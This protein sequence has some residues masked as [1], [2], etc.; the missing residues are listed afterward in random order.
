MDCIK[1]HGSGLH[2]RRYFINHLGGDVMKALAMFGNILVAI[3]IVILSICA[4]ILGLIGGASS[5]LYE[6]Y[7]KITITAI[8]CFIGLW[9]T[10]SIAAIVGSYQ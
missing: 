6:M 9:L 4:A 8:T 7:P 1:N 2:Y 3:I 10:Y 5:A